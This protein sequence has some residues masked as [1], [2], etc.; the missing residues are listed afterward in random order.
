LTVAPTKSRVLDEPT[1][2]LAATDVVRVLIASHSHP[3]ISKGG[4]EI[5]AYELYTAL[6]KRPDFDAYF[7]GCVRDE[8]NQKLGATIS[9]PFSDREYLYACGS[10]DWF[11]FSNT[12]PAFPREFR[13]LLQTL[14]PHIVHFH[15][16]IN[17][18]VEAF[19][20]A[21]ETLPECRIVVTLHEYLALCH[22]YGQM[23]TK[24]NATLCYES[25]PLRCTRCFKDI[26]PSDFF[27]RKLYI[28]RFCELVDQF[29]APS[30]FLAQRY[31]A[32]GIPEE[33][34]VTLENVIAAPGYCAAGVNA[35][36]TSDVLRVGFFGQISHLKGINVLMEAA[37]IL[38]DREA[39]N[40]VVEI[41]GD[42][43]GQP[44]EFQADFLKRLEKVGRNVKFYGPYDQHRVDKLMQSVDLVVIPSIWWENSPVVIQEALRNRRPIVCSDIGGMAEK[45][46]DGSDGF[47]F[48][49]GN[50]V[51]LASL[52][53][54]IAEK[55]AQLADLGRTMRMPEG[56]EQATVRYQQLYSN[57]FNESFADR[58]HS[59]GS[60]IKN[61]S[62]R[63]GDA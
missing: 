15:H 39:H 8:M 57:L 53:L 55:P 41:Y 17:F 23:V 36:G 60:A 26:T 24:Q 54:R 38:E 44:P 40:I 21:R 50:S 63:S 42:Y 43:S 11:K 34:M 1:G 58:R 3:K 12:D 27:L 52:L 62:Y 9:Q 48:P 4:A 22:H 7:L 10:F 2:G 45:V 18:G 28:Q 20:H 56:V 31:V 33:R 29:L 35:R 59:R 5:A 32:W 6:S 13:L 61:L 46:R 30:E 25:N 51:A 14:K 19:L 47:Q 16:Y 49:V 37:E